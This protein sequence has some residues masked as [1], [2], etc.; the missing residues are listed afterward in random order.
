M[1]LRHS[2]VLRHEEW[3]VGM[4]P[5]QGRIQGGEGRGSLGSDEPPL[6]AETEML[7]KNN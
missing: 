7:W 6:R 2:V 4:S 1:F 5:K 3:L